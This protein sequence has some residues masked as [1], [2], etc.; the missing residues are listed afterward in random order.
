MNNCTCNEGWTGDGTHCYLASVCRNH[1]NCH[2][3]ASC[4]ETFPGSVGVT[5]LTHYK[6]INF[7]LFQIERVCRR[8]F[9]I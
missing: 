6:M 2:E 8:Q 1:S 7:R 3:N 9:Q 4:I 5:P